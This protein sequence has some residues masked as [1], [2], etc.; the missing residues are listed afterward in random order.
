MKTLRLAA[1]SAV[2]RADALEFSTLQGIEPF[3]TTF[4]EAHL[5]D[6]AGP[7]TES[8]S[9]APASKLSA[10]AS[11]NVYVCINANFQPACSLIHWGNDVC[12]DFVNPWEDSISSWGPDPG[13][14]CHVYEKRGCDESG[15]KIYNVGN[16]G[17]SNLADYQ[18][19][20]I[21]SSA[22]CFY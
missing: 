6:F 1:A 14:T 18:F 13:V 4:A 9:V 12:A 20:D 22:R 2:P 10:R 3:N 7:V 19:N 16:P 17:I 8:A 11:G 21:I 15:R 5:V